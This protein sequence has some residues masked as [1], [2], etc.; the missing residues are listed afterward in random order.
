[1][2]TFLGRPISL[3][4]GYSMDFNLN[5]QRQFTGQGQS[6]QNNQIDR[7]YFSNRF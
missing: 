2:Q 1:M 3:G 6:L 5:N 7:K 4:S